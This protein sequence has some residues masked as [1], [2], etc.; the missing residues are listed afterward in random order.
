MSEKVKEPAEAG[1]RKSNRVVRLPPASAG[2]NHYAGRNKFCTP[3]H[4]FPQHR[5]LLL[6]HISDFPLLRLTF[7]SVFN[8]I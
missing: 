5:A 6:F 1:G 3:L 4:A 7:A 8:I 2:F